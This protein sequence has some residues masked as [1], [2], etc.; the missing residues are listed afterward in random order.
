MK[1]LILVAVGGGFGAVCRYW[2][3]T[4]LM[5]WAASGFPFGTLA[6]N[7]LGCVLIGLWAGLAARHAWLNGD[8]RLLLVSGV[9]GGFTTFSAFGLESLHLL[10]RGEWLLTGLYVG[11]S[12]LLG[13]GMALLGWWLAGGS[14]SAAKG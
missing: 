8:L 10:R 14:M 4:A 5:R 12:V 13:I 2:L 3:S 11:T 9:L 6:V 1:A 7:L